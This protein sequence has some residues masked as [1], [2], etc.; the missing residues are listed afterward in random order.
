MAAKKAEAME[1]KT[2]GWWA[3][4]MAPVLAKRLAELWVPRS[5]S[6][7]ESHVEHP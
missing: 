6:R 3:S 2:G 1:M 5:E 4:P 7:S